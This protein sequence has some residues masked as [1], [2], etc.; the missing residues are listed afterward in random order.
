ML[1]AHH[2]L[3]L[4]DTPPCNLGDIHVVAG[5]AAISLTIQHSARIVQAIV[6]CKG[7]LECPVLHWL[8]FDHRTL[9]AA[10]DTANISNRKIIFG[11]Y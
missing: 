9:Y 11:T 10:N 1:L 2:C 8:P 5:R 4:N 6:L 7:L 3:L